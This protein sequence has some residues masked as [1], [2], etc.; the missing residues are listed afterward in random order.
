[1]IW[2]Y[3]IIS[4]LIIVIIAFVVFSFIFKKTIKTENTKL[5]SLATLLACLVMIVIARPLLEPH[6]YAWTFE[7]S[8]RGKYPIID[9]LAQKSPEEFNAYVKKEKNEIIKSGNDKNNLT[10][11]YTIEF[12]DSQVAKYSQIAT[13]QSLYE[14]MQSRLNLF[15]MLI[16][17]NP[18]LILRLEFPRKYVD[19]T[20]AS[21]EKLDEFYN[22]TMQNSENVIKSAL[23]TPQTPPTEQD[24]KKAVTILRNIATGLTKKFGKEN[25]LLTFQDPTTPSLDKTIAANILI[26]LYEDILAT[27]VND[28]GTVVKY[29]FRSG[30]AK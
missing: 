30:N 11:F 1:M 9:L 16:D 26:S 20:N 12:L 13:N 10:T 28:T 17:T 24:S 5:I 15:K 19:E 29:V 21:L 18:E 2:L 7:S 27:G 3:R 25:V 23:E 6:F 8:I 22:K 4:Y 14:F